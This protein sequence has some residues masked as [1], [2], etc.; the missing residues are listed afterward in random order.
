MKTLLFSALLMCFVSA[1]K[2]QPARYQNALAHAKAEHKALLLRF[3][4]SDWCIPCIRMEKELFSDTS[5]RSYADSSLVILTADF[6]RLRKH[7]LAK[8]LQASNEWMAD[9]FN[10]EGSFPLIVLIGEDGTVLKK[11]EGLITEGAGKFAMEIESIRGRKLA[12]AY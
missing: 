7:Q 5:F 10:K 9:H 6:P 1:V 3:S 11:W 8:D 2:A 12:Y 4:G